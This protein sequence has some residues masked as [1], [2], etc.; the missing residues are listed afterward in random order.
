MTNNEIIR[1]ELTRRYTPAQLH[2]IAAAH[3][4]AQQIA[5]LAAQITVTDADGNKLDPLPDAELI[6]A[7][8]LFHTYAEWRKRGL[9][10]KCREKAAFSCMLWNWT[11]KPSAARRKAAEEAGEEINPDPHYYLAKAHLFSVDQVEE[12]TP[13]PAGRF[14]SIDEIK[15]YNAKLAAQRKAAKAAREAEAAH[16]AAGQPATAESKPVAHTPATAV[17]TAT[18][19]TTAHT[20][21]SA[22]ESSKPAEQAAAH[23]TTTAT[24]AVTTATPAP[25]NALT[26]LEAAERAAMNRFLATPETDRTAQAKAHNEWRAATAARE[27]AQAARG[28]KTV[29]TVA[30]PGL[31]IK[32]TVVPIADAAALVPTHTPAAVPPAV[33]RDFAALA[34]S[35][36]C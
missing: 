35:I 36:L 4:T 17:T 34:A 10:V 7:A 21:A 30:K 33:E 9:Q 6:L 14:K 19:A 12:P 18:T 31:S 1:N 32:K 11:D 27:A 22:T 23:T 24:T 3:Y 2:E 26:A 15:A 5:A 20:T 25:G 16:N 29:Y 8:K 13:A 28:E